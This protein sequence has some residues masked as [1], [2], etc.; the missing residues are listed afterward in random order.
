MRRP[1]SFVN[2]CARSPIFLF[3]LI[4]SYVP[5]GAEFYWFGFLIVNRNFSDTLLSVCVCVC[6]PSALRLCVLYKILKYIYSHKQCLTACVLLESVIF[7]V[8]GLTL[9]LILCRPMSSGLRTGSS[10]ISNLSTA[11][12]F[13][14]NRTQIILDIWVWN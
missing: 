13:L 12:L 7:V 9:N 11:D 2:T 6:I 14:G 5:C 10:N 4:L 8:F 1:L 3:C